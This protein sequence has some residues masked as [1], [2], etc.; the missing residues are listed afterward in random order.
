MKLRWAAVT[1]SVYTNPQSLS[2]ST[3][4]YFTI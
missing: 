1:W 3:Y 4:A 2:V